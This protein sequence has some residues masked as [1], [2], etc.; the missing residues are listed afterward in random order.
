METI[1][2]KIEMTAWLLPVTPAS[3]VLIMWPQRLVFN[4]EIAQLEQLVNTIST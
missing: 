2:R 1:V 4:V 3:L